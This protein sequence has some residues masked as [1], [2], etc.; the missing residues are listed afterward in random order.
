M[1]V[2]YRGASHE[3]EPAMQEVTEGE[4]GGLYRGSNMESS[5]SYAAASPLYN[6]SPVELSPCCLLQAS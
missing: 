4:I 6:A 3:A 2:S 1:R 5:L